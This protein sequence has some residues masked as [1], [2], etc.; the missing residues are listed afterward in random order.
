MNGRTSAG[1]DLHLRVTA[2]VETHGVRLYRL[3]VQVTGGTSVVN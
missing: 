1:T 3:L 2:D